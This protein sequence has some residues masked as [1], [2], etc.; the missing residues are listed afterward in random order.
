MNDEKAYQELVFDKSLDYELQ[1]E[2]E[3]LESYQDPDAHCCSM[4]QDAYGYCEICGGAVPGTFAY[5][6]EFGGD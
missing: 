5:H 1:Q 3:S 6:Q 2:L 4:H